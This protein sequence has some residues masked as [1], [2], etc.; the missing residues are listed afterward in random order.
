M[1]RMFLI[2]EIFTLNTLDNPPSIQSQVLI[3][4]DQPSS[5]LK[6]HD[7]ILRQRIREK[8]KTSIMGVYKIDGM[9]IPH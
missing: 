2:L 8:L 4:L 9:S 1:L 3:G 7:D 5:A 6:F